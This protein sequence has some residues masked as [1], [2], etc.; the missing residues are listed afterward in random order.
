M[1]RTWRR[2]PCSHLSGVMPVVDVNAQLLQALHVRL[3][4]TVAP[5]GLVAAPLCSLQRDGQLEAAEVHKV[6]RAAVSPPPTQSMHSSS[7]QHT[8]QEALLRWP[9]VQC[10]AQHHQAVSGGVVGEEL[11]C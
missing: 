2:S 7:C 8:E 6:L 3:C 11:L 1:K 9:Q 10:L 5:Q 4:F